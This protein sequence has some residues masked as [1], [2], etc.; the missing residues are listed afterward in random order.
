MERIFFEAGPG[1]RWPSFLENDSEILA[2]IVV[3]MPT[4]QL[5]DSPLY[6]IFRPFRWGGAY[7][8]FS[9]RKLSFDLYYRVVPFLYDFLNP[10]VSSVTAVSLNCWSFLPSRHP[11][12][13]ISAVSLN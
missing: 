8:V 6:I 9:Q 2:G 10:R 4:N 12:L 3:K 5:I 1:C 11:F 13:G 7:L